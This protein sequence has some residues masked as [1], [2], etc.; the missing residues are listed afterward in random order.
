MY[1]DPVCWLLGLV[2]TSNLNRFDS[3]HGLHTA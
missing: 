2:G 1:L 3:G